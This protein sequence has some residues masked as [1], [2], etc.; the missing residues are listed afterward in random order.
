MHYPTRSACYPEVVAEVT[1]P[2]SPR[3]AGPDLTDP[4]PGATEI[5]FTI[6]SLDRFAD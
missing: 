5:K 6:L 2:R 3:P 4:P 1:L